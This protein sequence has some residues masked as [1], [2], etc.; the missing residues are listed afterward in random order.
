MC[1]ECGEDAVTGNE[2]CGSYGIC[3]KGYDVRRLSCGLTHGTE[4]L[5]SVIAW[6]ELCLLHKDKIEQCD[7]S[8]YEEGIFIGHICGIFGK[9][10]HEDR[11]H[12]GSFCRI[13]RYR[14]QNHRIHKGSE[15]VN[16][17]VGD[18]E[19]DSQEAVHML[20]AGFFPGFLQLRFFLLLLKIRKKNNRNNNENRRDKLRKAERLL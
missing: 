15:T 11:I 18:R 9:T 13:I 2:G 3:G 5:C 17:A 20:H 8:D 16:D 7:D 4:K 1:P 6:E 19:E 10:M 12:K 14:R